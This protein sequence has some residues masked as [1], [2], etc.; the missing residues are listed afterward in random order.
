MGIAH[1]EHHLLVSVVSNSGVSQSQVLARRDL[2]SPAWIPLQPNEAVSRQPGAVPLLAI[3]V[4]LGNEQE[5]DQ[6]GELARQVQELT[7]AMSN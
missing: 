2:G 5:R 1:V 6:I 7:G 4:T 3:T